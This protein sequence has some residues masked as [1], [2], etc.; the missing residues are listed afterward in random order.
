MRNLLHGVL[1][2]LAVV[3]LSLARITPARAVPLHVDFKLTDEEYRPLAGVSVRL[4]FGT[5]DRQAPDAGTRIVTAADGTATFTIDAVINRRWQFRNIGFTPLSMPVRTDHVSVAAELEFV[6]PK[7]DGP[8]AVHR[9]LYTAEID[10]DGSGDCSTDDLDKVYEAGPDGRF[11]RLVGA[12]ASGP[13]FNVNIDGWSLSSAGYKLSDF[14]LEPEDTAAGEKRWHL[15]LAIMR[16]PKA[17][18]P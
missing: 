6:L 5:G 17:V 8:D 13:N 15:K 18:L 2:C 11:T 10:R 9:W 12:N 4:V 1:A 14:M 16:R 7:K 3:P